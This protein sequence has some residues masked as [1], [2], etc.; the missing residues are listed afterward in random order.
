MPATESLTLP[1]L[2]MTCASCQHHVEEALRSTAGVESARV[3]LIANRASVVFDPAVAAPAST[4]RG[5]SRRRLRRRPSP[6]RRFFFARHRRTQTQP[7]ADAKLG[8]A[9]RRSR[10]H[11]AGHAPGNRDGRARPRPHAHLALAL[12]ASAGSA[13]LVSAGSHGGHRRLGRPR[14]LLERHPRPAPRNHQHEHPGQPGNGRGLCSTPPTPPSGPRPA[15]RSTSTRFCSFSDFCCWAKPR[16]PRQTPRPGRARFALPPAPRHRPPHRRRRSK[17]LSRSKK[18]NPATAF[19]SFPA[20]AS[21][22]TQPFWKAAPRWT[23]PCSPANPRRCRASP[24]A[25]SSPARSTTT[26]PSPAALSRWA[27]PR[28]WRRSPAW[29]EQAQCSRA[30]ME[31]L[32]DRASSIFVPIVLALAAITFAAWLLA[33]HSLP[34]ALANTVA[35]LV[36]A[37]PCAMGLAVPA[38]LT[39]AVGRGAQL[40]ILFKGGEALERL[41]PSRCNRPRQNRNP[42]RRPTRAGRQFILLARTTP[43]TI[44]SAWPPQP[45]SDRTIPWP[46]PSS[47][48]R[49]RGICLAARGRR[50]DSP[51]PRPHR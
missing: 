48:P 1:V 14:H 41:S 5:H 30:P 46:T 18:F 19:W 9:H 44:C 16:S 23:N 24:A 37:C 49:G 32:A 12:C 35:V 11:A 45:R 22:W 36:I 40:G 31:R 27:R 26:A 51:R 4:A 43:K 50:T 29:F 3:D 47:M 20:S 8:H 39:V 13:A 34:L 25:A 28:C 38:A 15:A 2:G 6:R 42:D 17:P 7:E 10:R 21:R 33:A